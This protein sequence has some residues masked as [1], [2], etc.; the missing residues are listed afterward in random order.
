MTDY[1]VERY[2]EGVPSIAQREESRR[3]PGRRVEQAAFM[4]VVCVLCFGA[5]GVTTDPASTQRQVRRLVVTDREGAALVALE[6]YPD[7]TS[8]DRKPTSVAEMWE[9]T[10]WRPEK[11]S[12]ARPYRL[13]IRERKGRGYILAVANQGYYSRSDFTIMEAERGKPSRSEFES[14]SRSENNPVSTV[15][16]GETTESL[17]LQTGIFE[18]QPQIFAA[19]G[20]RGAQQLDIG[21]RREEGSAHPFDKWLKV[22]VGH[23]RTGPAMLEVVG[24][25]GPR[26]FPGDDKWTGDKSLGEVCRE[27]MIV[28]FGI[29]PENGGG[30]CGKFHEE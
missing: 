11:G 24:R 8:K 27:K 21:V 22:T 26:R 17:G 9:P 20:S 16:F 13:F 3:R 6:A 15:T 1:R 18:P 14:L 5:V 12:S 30:L 29:W 28:D 2:Q 4:A 7:L 25:V 10:L 19:L 23:H